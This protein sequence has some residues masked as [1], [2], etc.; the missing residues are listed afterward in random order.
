MPGW[1]GRAALGGRHAGRQRDGPDR[2]DGSTAP[3]NFSQRR[4]GESSKGGTDK[5]PIVIASAATALPPHVLSRPLVEAQVGPVFGLS[6]RRLDAVLE[7]IANS[8]IERRYSI[9]PVEY[10]IEP[11]SL[12]QLSCEYREHSVC[13]GRRA[14]SEA[15]QRAKVAPQDVDAI[16]TVS[17]T[18]FMIPSLDAYLAPE[19]GLRANV[20]RLPVTDRVVPRERLDFPSRV[21]MCWRIPAPRF[22]WFP[23]NCRR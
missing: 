20:R 1:D 5:E 2:P 16:I 8:Q 7:I 10:L 19:L 22:S 3:G 12:Q 6:G 18:G 4:V 15:L 11:R 9:F 14:A 17:C 23:S 21:I 13:L